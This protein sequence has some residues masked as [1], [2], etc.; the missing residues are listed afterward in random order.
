MRLR[1]FLVAT[2]AALVVPSAAVARPMKAHPH[3]HASASSVVG[4]WNVQVKEQE[5]NAPPPYPALA[6]LTVGHGVIATESDNPGTGLGSWK[7]IDRNRFSYAFQTFI[8]TPDGK[9][10]GYAAVRG[11][12]TVTGATWS[13]PFK[14]VVVDT[15]GKTLASG[16]GTATA[17]R[18]VI[19]PL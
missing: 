9:P 14:F 17:T 15:T 19:P 12:A 6:T 5:Q 2:L 7:Q 3:S 13:G 10:G 4:T 16:F 1:I 8:F 18:F 11:V